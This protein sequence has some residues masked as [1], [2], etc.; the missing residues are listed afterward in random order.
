MA[1]KADMELEIM[2]L[3]EKLLSAN[4]WVD[5]LRQENMA[6]HARVAE[7]LG[8][9]ERYRTEA[10]AA[11]KRE[12]ELNDQWSKLLAYNGKPGGSV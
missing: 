7:T 11:R 2:L 1:R 3:K 6:L 5:T 12:R 10:D 9:L 4:A 8:Q